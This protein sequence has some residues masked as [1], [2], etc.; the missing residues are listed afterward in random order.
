MND[1]KPLFSVC[2]PVYNGQLYLAA[3]IESVLSQREQSF[4]ILL[5]DDGSQ[6]TS[7]QICD[8]YAQ[9]YPNIRVL[10]KKNEGPML[11]R[12]DAVGMAQGRFLTFL[13]ADDLYLPHTLQRLRTALEETGADMILFDLELLHPQGTKTQLTESYANGTVFEG[14]GK[15]R[16]FQDFIMKSGMN[17]MCRKCIRRELYDAQADLRAYVGV[18]QGEDKLS[19]LHC[20]DQAQRIVYIRE[21]LYQYRM[22]HQSTSNNFTLKNYRDIQR[23][24]DQVAVY[25]QRWQLPREAVEKQQQRSVRSGCLCVRSLAGRIWQKK[26]TRQELRE[27]MAY[28]SADP[29]F[30]RG[31]RES[32]RGLDRG[33]RLV[34]WL[35]LRRADGILCLLSWSMTIRKTL[36]CK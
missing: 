4:E 6:D 9:R 20:L 28:I 26:A 35:I 34:S 3:C 27:A 29:S 13:D 2:I 33:D 17:S 23:V 16:L 30:Q 25:I 31:W 8:A 12:H 5:V 18:I 36:F 1:F 7:G 10:H 14:A 24:H 11:A 15:Q 21:S 22:N 32:R 19:S